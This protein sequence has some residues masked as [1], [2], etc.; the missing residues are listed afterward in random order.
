MTQH[1][2]LHGLKGLWL[3]YDQHRDPVFSDPCAVEKD[4]ESIVAWP[5]ETDSGK[6]EL[7]KE[8]CRTAALVSRDLAAGR[9]INDRFGI[10]I[11]KLDEHIHRLPSFRR[12]KLELEAN[13][14][15][16]MVDGQ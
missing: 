6:L 12:L 7:H 3:G 14:E 2:G 8:L 13:K 5:L 11:N 16:R 10:I 1:V 9:E 15:R 4:F